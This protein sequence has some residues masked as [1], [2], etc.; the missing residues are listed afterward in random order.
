MDQIKVII[1]GTTGMVGEGVL[2]ECLAN[3]AVSEVL[4][5]SRRPTGITHPKLKEFIVADFM[6]L[7]EG[8]EKLRGYD[9]CFFCAGIS[10]IGKSEEEYARITYDTTLHFARILANLNPG[11]IFTYV[12]GAGTDSTEKGRSM[13]ARVK[14]K[15]ENHLMRLP[16]KKV[17]NFRPGIM[18][19]VTGQQ[20]TLPA[21]KYVGWLFPIVKRLFPNTASTLNVVGRAMIRCVTSNVDKN[22]LEVSD[23]NRL[24]SGQ[25]VK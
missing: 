19:P 1:T 22:I 7:S 16:F 14:G 17:H 24:G 5:V 12:S 13:W 2:L 6:D 3:A 11:M 21:Y 18:K 25:G 20:Y 4:S 10:S 15:T 23:I 8:D 9:A